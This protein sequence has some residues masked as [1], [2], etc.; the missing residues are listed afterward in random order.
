M[1]KRLGVKPNPASWILSGYYWQTSAK[2]LR[3]LY[4]FYTCF[5]FSVL[6]LSTGPQGDYNFQ[7][8]NHRPD[9]R[10]VWWAKECISAT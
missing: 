5:C 3:S 7:S 10:A 8:P 9:C 4:L 2:W 1:E 6:W